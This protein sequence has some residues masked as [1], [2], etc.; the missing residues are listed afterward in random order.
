MSKGATPSKLKENGVGVELVDDSVRG[1][2]DDVSA[3]SC[4]Y[5]NCSAHTVYL[6]SSSFVFK[7]W[8]IQCRL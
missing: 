3:R 8:I 6:F 5:P 4:I 7:T 1:N 2:H